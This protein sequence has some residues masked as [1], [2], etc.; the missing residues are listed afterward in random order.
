[1]NSHHSHS[2][3]WPAATT[4]G[5]T[6]LWSNFSQFAQRQPELLVA[7]ALLGGVLLAFMTKGGRFTQ[8]AGSSPLWGSRAGAA[9][10]PYHT[11][12]ARLGAT[13]EQIAKRTPPPAPAL[14]T[15]T[16]G[17]TGAAFDLDPTSV[18]PG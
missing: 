8:R 17:V 14:E 9:R 7:G 5:R 16:A 13:E 11:P 3:D 4:G 2:T 6:T 15:G 12:A 18:T 1:M 10:A